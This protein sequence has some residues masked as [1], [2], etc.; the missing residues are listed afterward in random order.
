M[1]LLYEFRYYNLIP[2]TSE[3]LLKDNEELK[4]DLENMRMFLI[5]KAMDEK[6]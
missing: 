2:I 1:E 4:E 6:L 3:E 5:D